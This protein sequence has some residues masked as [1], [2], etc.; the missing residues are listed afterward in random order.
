MARARL[1]IFVSD[2]MRSVFPFNPSIICVCRILEC[3][4]NAFRLVATELYSKNSHLVYHGEMEKVFYFF[5]I[6]TP[7]KLRVL[8]SFSRSIV[9][10]QFFPNPFFF[11][12]RLLPFY[13][14]VTV[15]KFAL[16][17]ICVLIGCGS[18][19]EINCKCIR[20]RFRC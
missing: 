7:I 4:V 20:F 1:F 19:N 11:V 15:V 10:I 8:F 13:F 6:G 3:S 16:I 5:T 18:W 17:L 2:S 12:A 14:R 9:A